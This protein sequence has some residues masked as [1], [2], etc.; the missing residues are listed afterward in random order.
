MA[1][2]E[3]RV[4][5]PTTQGPI[6]QSSVMSKQHESVSGPPTSADIAKLSH[7]LRVR[8]RLATVKAE[9]G[10]EYLSLS[11]TEQKLREE[12]GGSGSSGGGDPSSIPRSDNDS[13]DTTSAELASSIY[14]AFKRLA[15]DVQMQDEECQSTAA[16]GVASNTAALVTLPTSP[17]NRTCSFTIAN[18]RRRQRHKRQQVHRPYEY[19]RPKSPLEEEHSHYSISQLQTHRMDM[20]NVERNLHTRR[21]YQS[22]HQHYN[23]NYRSSSKHD[24][25]SISIQNQLPTISG[26]SLLAVLDAERYA[27]QIKTEMPLANAMITP[28][29]SQE[30]DIATETTMNN[31]NNDGVDSSSSSTSISSCTS[32]TSSCISLNRNGTN[33][34][35]GNSLG[36]VHRPKFSLGQMPLR[37]MEQSGATPPT[38]P[39]T[40][41]AAR[42]MIL[43]ANSHDT[44]NTSSMD[45]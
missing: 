25:S 30:C 19:Q 39:D 4:M 17:T 22:D 20:I 11:E 28:A 24:T 27:T 23:S 6:F 16:S 10:W 15:K 2:D 44:E 37:D 21:H 18:E 8:L 29:S 7:I 34:V 36:G 32:S 40:E 35:A 13:T 14:S 31:D 33:T 45:R 9:R 12:D 38:S 41:Q 26:S 3:S 5:G 42:L 1:T 43:L